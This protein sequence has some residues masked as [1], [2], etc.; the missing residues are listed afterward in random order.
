MLVGMVFGEGAAEIDG[1]PLAVGEF[2]PVQLGLTSRVMAVHISIAL[3][4]RPV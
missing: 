2:A 1:L 4:P 3:Y